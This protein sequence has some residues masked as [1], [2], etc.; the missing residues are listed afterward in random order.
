MIPYQSNPLGTNYSYSSEIAK[1]DPNL[2][3]NRVVTRQDAQFRANTGTNISQTPGMSTVWT[4]ESGN[5]SASLFGIPFSA[6]H[7][8]IISK[9]SEFACQSRTQVYKK[10]VKFATSLLSTE[11]APPEA[12]SHQDAQLT[13]KEVV[14]RVS[15]LA[16][17]HSEE[18]SPLR[19]L[20]ASREAKQGTTVTGLA[21]ELSLLAHQASNADSVLFGTRTE[22]GH[23]L[24]H[25]ESINKGQASL[26]QSAYAPNNKNNQPSETVRLS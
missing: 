14:N 3:L 9:Q 16:Q 20:L 6:A 8:N 2:P 19:Q 4:R 18:Q 22:L 17:I 23:T 12:Q 24:D 10:M 7:T 5:A 11:S 13:Y 25:I 26:Q 15:Q 1:K 21:D